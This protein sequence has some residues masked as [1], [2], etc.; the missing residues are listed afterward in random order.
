M[1]ASVT[2]LTKSICGASL[3]EGDS[4][5]GGNVLVPHENAAVLRKYGQHLLVPVAQHQQVQQQQGDQGVG[6]QQLTIGTV[7]LIGIRTNLFTSQLFRKFQ[8]WP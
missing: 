2:H 4:G 5:E 8:I 7:S 6:S 3:V 1:H